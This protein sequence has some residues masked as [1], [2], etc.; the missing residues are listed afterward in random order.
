MSSETTLS[1]LTWILYFEIFRIKYRVS[2]FNFHLQC[3]NQIYLTISKAFDQNFSSDQS[4]AF[5]R[6]LW[7]V[8]E[9]QEWFRFRRIQSKTRIL[10]QWKEGKDDENTTNSYV[11][12]AN[13][14]KYSSYFKPMKQ[15]KNIEVTLT[16]HSQPKR[17]NGYVLKPGTSEHLGTSKFMVLFC[18]T[19]QVL[20][21]APGCS[22]VFRGVP[23]CSGVFRGVLVFRC[24]W[25][26]TCR[27]NEPIERFSFAFTANVK[28]Q[29]AACCLS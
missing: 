4:G 12:A 26:S 2:S 8:K 1:L 24:S 6:F 27:Q 20:R 19:D 28:L 25:S 29:T 13:K 5:F 18:F 9:R 21:G 17:Q 3:V 10:F 23:G 15:K 22:G 11:A 7:T 14:L 16:S